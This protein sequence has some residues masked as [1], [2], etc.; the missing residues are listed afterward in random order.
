MPSRVAVDEVGGDHHRIVRLEGVDQRGVHL[1]LAIGPARR[2]PQEERHGE[3]DPGR[4][5]EAVGEHHEAALEP[6]AGGGLVQAHRMIAARGAEEGDRRGDE[7]HQ[8]DVGHHHAQ[9]GDH[10]EAAQHL[11]VRD[12][13]RSEAHR[14]GHRGQEARDGQRMHRAPRREEP[15]AGLAGFLDV[16]PDDVHRLRDA[17]HD[18]KR[19]QRV[20]QDGEGLPEERHQPE[21]R[22]HREGHR[23]DGEQGSGEPPE[24]EE[25]KHHAHEQRER[26]EHDLVADHRVG[27]RRAEMGQTGGVDGDAVGRRVRCQ[28]SIDVVHR[29]DPA[30]ADPQLRVEDEDDRGH[31]PVFAH[32]APAQ[33]RG[34]LDRVDDARHVR[35]GDGGSGGHEG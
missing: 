10:P 22:D 14:G 32:Q 29:G 16:P 1:D 24:R 6:A 13:E 23:Q 18:E 8:D 20:H 21:H 31:M 4:L 34:V 9:R 25:E 5:Q 12:R 17:H 11:G 35:L 30:V 15:I 19:R 28:P 33:E 26:H 2:E 27:D 3:H 7:G